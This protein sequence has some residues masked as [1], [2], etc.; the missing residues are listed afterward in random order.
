METAET[1]F[2]PQHFA[3]G[4]LHESYPN[5]TWILQTRGSSR[6]WA[7]SIYHWHSMTRRIFDAFSLPMNPS[8]AISQAPDPKTRVSKEEIVIDMEQQ[9]QARVYN[10]TE[11]LRKLVLLEWI[12]ENHTASIYRWANQFNTHSLIH[13]NVDDAKSTTERLDRVLGEHLDLS[14]GRGRCEW[15]Y[16]SQTDDWKDFS[17]PFLP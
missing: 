1:W 7:E 2:L 8:H 14:R 16:R 17:F 9:L 13:I 10:T 11:H 5:A 6:E 3:L 15:T 4:L 12:Y